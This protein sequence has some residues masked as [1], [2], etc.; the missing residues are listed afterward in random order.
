MK[1]AVGFATSY[2]ITSLTDGFQL[3]ECYVVDRGA[4]DLLRIAQICEDAFRVWSLSWDNVQ[5]RYAEK[6]SYCVHMEGR[7]IVDIRDPSWNPVADSSCEALCEALCSAD[8]DLASGMLV[9]LEGAPVA[10]VC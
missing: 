2:A 10:A 3:R 7:R 4:L 6:W 8:D 1:P 9:R 5:R